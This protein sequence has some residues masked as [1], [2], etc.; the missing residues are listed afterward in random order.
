MMLLLNQAVNYW[1]KLMSKTCQKSTNQHRKE[2][3]EP[4]DA[5]D[6]LLGLTC[7]EIQ[8]VQRKDE[9]LGPLI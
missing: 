2:V 9:S 5:A 7:D 6:H 4:L 1:N 8:D 3:F